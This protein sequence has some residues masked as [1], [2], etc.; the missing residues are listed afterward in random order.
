MPLFLFAQEKYTISGYIKDAA[1]GEALIGATVL[2]TEL[3]TG[4]ITNVYGFY[5]VTLP[6]GEYNVEYRYIGFVTQNQRVNLTSN[7]RIDVEL[8]EESTQLQEVVVTARPEDEN[9][10]S[11]QMS[12]AELDIQTVRKMPAILGE[13]DVIKSLQLLPGV[14]S[15]GEGASGFN[16]RGGDVGQNLILLD[17]APVYN[18]S[19]LLGFFSV[20]NPDAVKDLKLYKGAIPAQFGG[21]LAS[22]L[23]IRMKEG[24]SKKTEVNGGIGTIFSRLAV[25]APIVKDKSSFIVAGRR[26][27]ADILA[28]PFVQELRDGAALNFY[29]LTLKTNYQFSDKDQIFLSGYF[30]R[31]NFLFDAN[32]GFSWGNR[33]GTFRWNH[34]FNDRLFANFT[35]FFSDYE[36]ELAFGD[37]PRDRFEWF[38]DINTFALKPS[39]TYFID[40]KN[41]LSFGGELYRYGFKPARARGISDGDVID[42]SVPDK[43]ALEAAI[44]INNDQKINDNLSVQYGLRFSYFN[45]IGEGNKFILGDTIP[46]RRRPID[47]IDRVGDGESIASHSGWEPRVS[48][49]YQLNTSTSVK[50]SYNRMLQYIHLISNTTA[51]NPLDVW[52]PSSNNLKPQIGQQW[53]MGLF[54][55]FKDN[56]YET[57][58]EVYYRKTERQLEYINGA[59]LLINEALEADL[60]AG[61]G[62]AYGL[63]VYLRKN[64]GRLNGWISYTLGRSELRTE[65]INNREWYPTR[66]D[67][68]HNLKVTGFYELN[69]RWSLSSTF[70]LLSGTPTTFPTDRYEVQGITIPHNTN[71][72]RNN[73]RLPNF[74]RLDFSATK[75]GRA[76]RRNGKPRKN[77]DELVFTVYN[78]YNRAN[79][80]SIYFWQGADRVDPGLRAD[81]RATQVSIFASFIPSITYN[82][83][84]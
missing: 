62:R 54:K 29:D 35:T 82:F 78:V 20:F 15:V 65:G 63:E 12:V 58:V 25:E 13:V 57:S 67:Q 73:V 6:A 9:V 48:L 74:H 79:P 66:F 22:I 40:Q 19:H 77:R 33:T 14:S 4:N 1:N 83:K 43:N 71:D 75:K 68:T 5:S 70:T 8:S 21:R 31:D 17:E 59:D 84:F 46:G 41:E 18:S 28:R 60:L 47:D 16:V 44:Y 50:A 2:I 81:T 76:V 26:S 34:L 30:G 53:A 69:D 52:T 72:S 36:Y 27:Y 37:N 39:F 42:I 56:D 45:L 3:S 51:S 11:T 32:Q 38:S 24:N 7:Q 23:D 10:T 61:D 64:S 49:K 80:F 55:N